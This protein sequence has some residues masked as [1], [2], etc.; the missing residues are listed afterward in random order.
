MASNI[1]DT[2]RQSERSQR[3]QLNEDLLPASWSTDTPERRAGGGTGER[4]LVWPP[5]AL[6]AGRGTLAASVTRVVGAAMEENKG[7]ITTQSP[8]LTH[9]ER[10]RV[11]A[12][13]QK[14]QQQVWRTK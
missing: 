6:A 3:L 7:T 8:N 4:H 13:R 10:N 12:Q 9:R 14:W 1:P 2:E 5:G 11:C